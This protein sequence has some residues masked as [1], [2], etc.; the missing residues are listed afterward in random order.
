M[1]V[2]ERGERDG[3]YALVFIALILATLM[4]FMALAIDL[5]GLYN[6]RRQ[7]QSAADAGALAGIQNVSSLPDAVAK[8]KEYAAHTLGLTPSEFDWNNCPSVADDPG[9]LPLAAPGASCITYNVSATQLRVRV[10]TQQLKTTFANAIGFSNF[11]HSASA[12]AER[13]NIGFGGV[14]PFG[15]PGGSGGLV[16]PKTPPAGLSFPPCSGPTSPGAFGFIDI[17]WWYAFGSSSPSCQPGGGTGRLA[18]NVAAGADHQ[19]SKHPGDPAPEFAD[20]A[21]CVTKTEVPNA[22]DAGGGVSGN[23]P[24][25]LATGL[26]S[27]DPVRDGLGGRLTRFDDSMFADATEFW[28]ERQTHTIDDVELDITPLWYFIDPT[29]PLG[30]PASCS[31]D[32]FVD[33]SGNPKSDLSG[34][35]PNF[36]SAEDRAVFKSLVQDR[37]GDSPQLAMIALL[38]RCFTHFKGQSWGESGWTISPPEPSTCTTCVGPIFSSP[39]NETE[40]PWDIQFSPRFGYVPEFVTVPD[41]ATDEPILRFR[42][43]Y[44]QASCLVNSAACADDESVLHAGFADSDSGNLS[45]SGG[46]IAWSFADGMLPGTLGDEDAPNLSPNVMYLLIR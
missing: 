26:Y 29:L 32:V 36:A 25:Q 24:N 17:A 13:R 46:F 9:R 18:D 33:S 28:L 6:A 34:L 38:D 44:I 7:D 10:P 4:G 12:V 8:A 42:A 14:L 1:S 37:V 31:R 27:A 40:G 39:E 11:G 30:A 3:G 2:S 19:I 5:G 45:Q 20:A 15:L 16:C 43:I 35:V 23:M 22:L 41:S 21:Y